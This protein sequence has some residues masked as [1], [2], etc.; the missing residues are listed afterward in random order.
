MTL[1]EYTLREKLN[2][3]GG[4][5]IG[6]A[7]PMLM[8]RYV[9]FGQL[10]QGA[11]EDFTAWGLTAILNLWPISKEDKTPICLTGLLYGLEKGAECARD[12]KDRREYGLE[13]AITNA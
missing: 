13:E 6:A 3:Y 12:L 7:V 8:T 5:I 10:N 9:L 1:D 11:A 4:A 2:I